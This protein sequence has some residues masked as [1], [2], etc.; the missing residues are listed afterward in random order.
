MSFPQLSWIPL[1]AVFALPLA[2]GACGGPILLAAVSY[3]ADGVSLVSTGK[4]STDHLISMTSQQDCA[5]WRAVQGKAICK[6]RED[7]VDPYDVD[8]RTPER[9]QSEDGSYYQAP[10]RS[11]SAVPP[12]SWDANPYKIEPAEAPKSEPKT[13]S[14]TA[15]AL[16][17]PAPEPAV[18]EAAPPPT[19]S[20][21]PVTPAAK[22]RAS[23]A[24]PKKTVAKKPSPGPAASRS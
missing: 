11:T 15:T 16:P 4:T 8:Y 12:T 21:P 22:K 14:M 3:G 23:G 5:M 19:V 24:K 2:T 6:E 1:L 10:L 13:E 7:G 9:L 18:A 17:P 20:P